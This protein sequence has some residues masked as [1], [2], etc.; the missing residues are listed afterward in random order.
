MA[1][2]CDRATPKMSLEGVPPGPRDAPIRGESSG[3]RRLSAVGAGHFAPARRARGA[4][5][6]PRLAQQRRFAPLSRWDRRIA[7][8]VVE[9]SPGFPAE[10]TCLR[11]P[12]EQRARTVF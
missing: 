8:I 6:L 10:P 3:A 7:G 12:H 4:A 5:G 2:R 9:A 1:L 11:V